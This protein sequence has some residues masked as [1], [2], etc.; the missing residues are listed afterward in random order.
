[1]QDR[2][3]VAILGNLVDPGEASV[4]ALAFEMPDSLLILDDRKGRQLAA[5]LQ[6]HLTGLVGVLVQA[7]RRGIIA[8][9]GAELA[10]LRSAGFRVSQTI[11]V[12]AMHLAG[13]ARESDDA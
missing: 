12:K 3:R 13:E 11:E 6:L 4:I 1:V 10:A 9:L 5:N 2:T 7:R 8:S